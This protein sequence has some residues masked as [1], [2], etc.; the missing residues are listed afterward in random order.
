MSDADSGRFKLLCQWITD[1]FSDHTPLDLRTASER[2]L[3]EWQTCDCAFLDSI[4]LTEQVH[5][6]RFIFIGMHTLHSLIKSHFDQFTPECVESLVSYLLSFIDKHQHVGFVPYFSWALICLADI[7]LYLSTLDFVLAQVWDQIPNDDCKLHMLLWY[8][9][10]SAAL[11]RFTRN[12]HPEVVERDCLFG[13]QQLQMR[14][15]SHLWLQILLELSH[16]IHDVNLCLELLPRM[17]ENLTDAAMVNQIIE[18]ISLLVAVSPGSHS[19]VHPF[20]LDFACR[21]SGYLR[22]QDPILLELLAKLWGR[23]LKIEDP[24]NSLMAGGFLPRLS[25]VFTEFFETCTLLFEQLEDVESWGLLFSGCSDM[26]QCFNDE[27][28]LRDF[29]VRSVDLVV[30]VLNRGIPVCLDDFLFAVI[31][32]QVPRTLLEYF[33]GRMSEGIVIVITQ[34]SRASAVL[35]QGEL[36]ASLLPQLAEVMPQAQGATLNRLLFA[37]CRISLTVAGTEPFLEAVAELARARLTEF[38]GAARFPEAI[39]IISA[40]TSVSQGQFPAFHAFCVDLIDFACQFCGDLW[41]CPDPEIQ[42]HLVLLVHTVLSQQMISP[43]ARRFVADWINGMIGQVGEIRFL[44]C[45]PF[46]SEFLPLENVDRFL[47]ELDL[48]HA[49]VTERMEEVINTMARVI[50]DR[51]WDFIPIVWLLRMLEGGSTQTSSFV[52][53]LIVKLFQTFA[54]PDRFE[55][56]QRCLPNPYV[57]H[58]DSVLRMVEKQ[59][60]DECPSYLAALRELNAPFFPI[61]E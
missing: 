1:L 7:S 59:A 23:V 45:L 27:H 58:V 10:D 38:V 28:P 48:R 44:V 46:L 13:I 9:Q 32:D 42:Y 4:A 55:L 24:E 49:V 43:P 41:A 21:L 19:L 31:F 30:E 14:P 20:C 2:A 56:F 5:E 8:L 33:S 47:G 35:S 29:V 36:L 60:P 57:E 12:E 39:E 15:V 37:V 54:P 34:I 51:I 50:P 53:S 40:I 26:C 52:L 25:E 6:P 22:S 3:T 11:P 61:D 16:V 17:E 18:I